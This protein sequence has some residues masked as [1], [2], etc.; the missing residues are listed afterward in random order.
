MWMD[1]LFASVALVPWIAGS[2]AKPVPAKARVQSDPLT[3]AP[4]TPEAGPAARSR[5]AR[6]F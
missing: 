4:L 6:G 5:R 1:L 3:P 2:R